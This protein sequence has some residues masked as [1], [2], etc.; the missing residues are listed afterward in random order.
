MQ[1]RETEF[2]VFGEICDAAVTI[3]RLEFL[4][5]MYIVAMSKQIS[6]RP[7]RV[8]LNTA[9]FLHMTAWYLWTGRWLSAA[10]VE[11][12]LARLWTDRG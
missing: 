5:L 3:E 2:D 11:Y 10:H 8:D 6:N 9:M 7:T 4:E 12:Y 1:F